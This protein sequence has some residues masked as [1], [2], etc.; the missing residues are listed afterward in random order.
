MEMCKYYTS[1]CWSLVD[2][3]SIF[4]LALVQILN[5]TYGVHTDLQE[6]GNPGARCGGFRVSQAFFYRAL[7]DPSTGLRLLGFS[8][9]ARELAVAHAP[10]GRTSGRSRGG[11]LNPA[12]A[13]LT[14]DACYHVCNLYNCACHICSL[15]KKSGR[16][17]T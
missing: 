11:L 6:V 13:V 9:R 17:I 12:K 1:G 2:L 4:Q 10:G 5:C 14:L 16:S 7:I 8:T 15:K 3:H